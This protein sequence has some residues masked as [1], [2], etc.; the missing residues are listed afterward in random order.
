[1]FVLAAGLVRG[2]VGRA[3]ITI[4]ENEIAAKAMGMNLARY[5]TGTFAV[6]AM[7]A[8]VGGALFSLPIGFVAPESFPLALSFAFLAAIVVGGLATIGGALFGALFIEFV[9]VLAADTNVALAGVI[10]GGVL[11]LFM[12]LLPGG[13]M[14]IRR[15]V[16]RP[17]GEGAGAGDTRRGEGAGQGRGRAA[18]RQ[19]EGRVVM[20]RQGRLAGAV[21]VVALTV[22]VGRRRPRRGRRGAAGEAAAPTRASPTPR[23]SSAGSIR[24]AGRRRR[25]GRSRAGAKA[26]FDFVN[27]KGGVDGR[28]I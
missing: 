15:A 9:P 20:V 12:Y 21:A 1:M 7:Y 13:V 8:G 17:A 22:L 16:R 26:H 19:S 24:S 25:T 18:R 28:K 14:G 23:S 2:R 6:S 11:I 3:L 27:D 10:Y 5:K 4:R